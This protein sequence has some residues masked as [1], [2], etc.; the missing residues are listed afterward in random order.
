M[1]ELIKELQLGES[2]TPV[3]TV[4]TLLIGLILTAMLSSFVSYVYRRVQAEAG[5]SQAFVQTLV[6]ISMITCLIMLVIG[7]NIARAF[8]LLGALSIIRFRT[9]IRSPL[10]V[11]FLFLTMAIGMAC[12]TRF[13]SVAVVGTTFICGIM[14]TQSKLNFGSNPA[15]REYLLSV[16]FPAGSDYEMAMDSLLGKLFDAYSV[17]YVE[18]VRQGTMMEVVYSVRPQEG[19]KQQDV[20]YEV[21]K[22]NGNLKITYRTIH[23][24]IEI[25]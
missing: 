4:W 17:S 24:A 7:S 8:S 22:V 3:T 2:I 11:A 20:L 23:N 10:D 1:H 19:V 6:L 12:G 5:Y 18:T 14:L 9:A 15:R 21:A 13:Y 16:L 25:P